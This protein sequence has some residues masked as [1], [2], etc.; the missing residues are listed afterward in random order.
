MKRAIILA[1]EFIPQINVGIFK[2][3]IDTRPILII[4]FLINLFILFQ[5]LITLIGVLL[6]N[7]ASEP[8]LPTD[9]SNETHRQSNNKSL[10]KNSQDW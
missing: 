5:V 7:S 1:A 6:A 3:S 9:W 8:L 10:N 4:L 2:K